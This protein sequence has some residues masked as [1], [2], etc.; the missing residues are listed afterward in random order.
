ME[1]KR[2]FWRTGL[3]PQLRFIRS[4]V[5]VVVLFYCV[6]AYLSIN[7]IKEGVFLDRE[8]NYLLLHLNFA[9]MVIIILIT[10]AFILHRTFG[11]LWRMQKVLEGVLK[12]DY[13]QRIFLRK[14]DYLK[15]LADLLNQLIELFEKKS[16][17]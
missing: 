4:V 15:P 11:G 13:S 1:K 7:L 12:G 5:L 14:G 10:L 8:L 2:F 3:P 6:N 9:A 17:S 16:K